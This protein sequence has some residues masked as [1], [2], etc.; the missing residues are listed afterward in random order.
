MT[1]CVAGPTPHRS[2]AGLPRNSPGRMRAGATG[3]SP[4][5]GYRRRRSPPYRHRCLFRSRGTGRSRGRRRAAGQFVHPADHGLAM[6]CRIVA[7]RHV[8]AEDTDPRG[9]VELRQVHGPIEP[10]EMLVERLGDPD[11]PDRRADRA[12][13]E[14]RASSMSRNS[15]CWASDRS[16][17]FVPWMARNSMSLMP[18]RDRTSS[19]SWGSCEIS[20]AKALM[21]IIDRFPG[22][23][24]RTKAQNRCHHN[25]VGGKPPG[26]GGFVDD[27]PSRIRAGRSGSTGARSSRFWLLGDGDIHLG[28]PDLLA[29]AVRRV[30][31]RGR[32]GPRSALR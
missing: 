28:P 22:H 9:S 16:R 3:N 13:T 26:T 19:C 21:R 14:P 31:R 30:L 20:S 24:T 10:L 12:E 17:T 4:S 6:R 25:E 15:A 2:A 11:L 29:G 8:E 7:G 5:P 27:D 1:K 32:G 18:C 23:G